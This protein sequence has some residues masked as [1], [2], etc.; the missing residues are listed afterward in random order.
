M[1]TLALTLVT[2]KFVHACICHLAELYLLFSLSLRL[3]YYNG[4]TVFWFDSQFIYIRAT[5]CSHCHLVAPVPLP[6]LAAP[7]LLCSLLFS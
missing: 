5:Q 1:P 2:Y 3:Y 7:M 4:K 6:T